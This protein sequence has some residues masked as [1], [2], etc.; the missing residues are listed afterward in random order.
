MTRLAAAGFTG[1]KKASRAFGVTANVGVGV[2]GGVGVG[3][4]D[5]SVAMTSSN[6]SGGSRRLGRNR[7]KTTATDILGADGEDEEEE[8]EAG[9][10]DETS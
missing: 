5:S 1:I 9:V 8:G 7:V 10:Y 4:S 6:V 2:G 3:Q